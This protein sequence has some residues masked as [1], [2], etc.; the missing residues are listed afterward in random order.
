MPY[1]RAEIAVHFPV[2]I[3]NLA[4]NDFENYE[5]FK[6]TYAVMILYKYE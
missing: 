3:K 4:I 5:N 6:F 2:P 1:S